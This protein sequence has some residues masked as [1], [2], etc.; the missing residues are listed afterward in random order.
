[1]LY[2]L[3]YFSRYSFV[4]RCSFHF[5]VV[6]SVHSLSSPLSSFTPSH[7][8]FSIPRSS[9]YLF[10]RYI[11]SVAPLATTMPPRS[12]PILLRV[13]HSPC[14]RSLG[15]G[16]SQCLRYRPELLSSPTCLYSSSFLFFLHRPSVARLLLFLPA[17]LALQ[18]S[19]THLLSPCLHPPCH[20]VADFIFEHFFH[21][22]FLSSI[23]LLARPFPFLHSTDPLHC[24]RFFLLLPTSRL[25]LQPL[26]NYSFLSPHSSCHTTKP[27]CTMGC[28][29]PK[30]A[31]S[32]VRKLWV[33]S[34]RRP[35]G[36]SA[37]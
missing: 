26:V 25:H 24:S 20:V 16:L 14:P 10:F 31:M 19:S 23:R 32:S 35:H 21:S 6:S 37:G 2:F 30:N 22:S 27:F 1:M 11:L 8:L 34:L 12:R 18:R 36:P 15:H 29:R 28:A 5:T 4:S 17:L 9:V 13:F 7:T 33:P 3:S